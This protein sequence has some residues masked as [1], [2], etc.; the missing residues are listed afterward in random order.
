ML[1]FRRKVSVTQALIVF[2]KIQNPY[3]RR[4]SVSSMLVNICTPAKAALAEATSPSFGSLS[5]LY[6]KVITKEDTIAIPMI[7]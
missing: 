6:M 7:V 4:A 1:F 5:L 2:L 3:K